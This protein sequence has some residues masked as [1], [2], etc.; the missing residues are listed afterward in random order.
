[1]LGQT[2]LHLL[3]VEEL[4]AVLELKRELLLENLSVLLDLLGVSIL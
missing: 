4:A 1:M 2:G 3:L